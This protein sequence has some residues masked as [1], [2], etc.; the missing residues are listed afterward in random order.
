MENKE[1]RVLGYCKAIAIG[2]EALAEVSGGANWTTKL[3]N[4]HS[5]SNIGDVDFSDN[6]VQIDF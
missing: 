4:A 2:R 1:D 3:T 5:G 6:D